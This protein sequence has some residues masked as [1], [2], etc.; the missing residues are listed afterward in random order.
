MGVGVELGGGM[1][2]GGPFLY[3]FFYLF[4]FLLLFYSPII[5]RLINM[6]TIGN[7][8]SIENQFARSAKLFFA[9]GCDSP[10]PQ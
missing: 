1:H 5:A 7:L 4:I 6:V 9:Q 3:F 10:E 8:Y 2:G